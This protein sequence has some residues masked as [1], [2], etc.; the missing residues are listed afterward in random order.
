[1]AAIIGSCNYRL[2]HKDTLRIE[3]HSDEAGRVSTRFFEL[4]TSNRREADREIGPYGIYLRTSL[5]LA[6]GNVTSPAVV[7]SSFQAENQKKV[8]EFLFK[9]RSSWT[10]SVENHA[11]NKWDIAGVIIDVPLPLYNRIIR[12]Y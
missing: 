6:N 5:R 8:A 7:F 2:N 12:S 9:S 4:L 3:F 1:M 11:D 10:A